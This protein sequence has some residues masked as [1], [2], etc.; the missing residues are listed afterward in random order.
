MPAPRSRLLY[1][2]GGVVVV[3][4]AMGAAAWF[5]FLKGDADPELKISDSK[6]GTGQSVDSNGLDGTWKV[7]A[8]SGDDAT[9]AGYQVKEKF[10]D[11]LRKVTASGRTS[12]VTGTLTVAGAKVTKG[13]FTVDMTTLTSDRPQRDNAIRHDGLETDRF[14]KSSF[15][16]SAPITLPTVADGKVFQVTAS[17]KL[18]LHGVTRSVRVPISAKVTGDTVT[19]QGAT[20]IKIGL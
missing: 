10:A 11:G 13:S 14:P 7:V 3:L 18:T 20:P 4:V 16:L 17:G 6:T 1:I 2:V 19:I 15:E 5:L 12:D 8:G 9:V